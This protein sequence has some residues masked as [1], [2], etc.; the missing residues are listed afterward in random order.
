[1]S[2]REQICW[3]FHVMYSVFSRIVPTLHDC[4]NHYRFG[5]SFP[6]LVKKFCHIVSVCIMIV[7]PCYKDWSGYSSGQPDRIRTALLN[8]T[9]ALSIS[10][11][12]KALTRGVVSRDM[13][14]FIFH[15]FTFFS[16][17]DVTIYRFIPRVSYR[18]NFTVI[19]SLTFIAFI[20]V[21]GDRYTL[22]GYLIGDI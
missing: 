14:H 11:R 21:A 16:L 6:N 7:A 2:E 5:S 19:S 15:Q 3:L 9:G 10:P 17:P 13:P 1:M 12:E 22:P 4:S 20:F 8:I 18:L